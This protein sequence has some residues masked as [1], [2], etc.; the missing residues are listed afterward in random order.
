MKA[1]VAAPLAQRRS[2]LLPPSCSLVL[3][4]VRSSKNGSRPSLLWPFCQ[5]QSAALRAWTCASPTGTLPSAPSGAAPTCQRR[6]KCRPRTDPRYRTTLQTQPRTTLD[7]ATL[8]PKNECHLTDARILYAGCPEY[9]SNCSELPHCSSKL[10]GVYDTDPKASQLRSCT[11][12]HVW[13][14]RQP[15]TH[16]VFYTYTF[17]WLNVFD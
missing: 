11:D 8:G 7:S 3:K 14:S 2:F 16:K 9:I 15:F 4:G 5:D 17:D 6:R 12:F 1:G 10:C 13:V